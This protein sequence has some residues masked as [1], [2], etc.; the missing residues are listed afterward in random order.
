MS[1]KVRKQPNGKGFGKAGW[2]IILYA[3]VL[4][5]L[6]N[7]AQTDG[8]NLFVEAFSSQNGWDANSVL[9]LSTPAG[10][11]GILAGIP[12]GFLT[13]KKGPKFVL[14]ACLVI[15][16][17]S[18]ACYGFS[19]T[20][21][22]YAVSLI[23]MCCTHNCFAVIAINTLL[24][25]WFPKKK[26]LALGWATMGMNLSSALYTPILSFLL[27]RFTLGS[28]VGM[29]AFVTLL[30]GVITV[31]VI[32]DTPEECGCTPDN[33]YLT[34]AQ[35]AANNAEHASYV[36]KNTF[37]SLLKDKDIWMCGLTYGC[38]ML[39]TTGIMSQL[40]SRLMARG[41]SQTNAI[42]VMSIAAVIGL[43]GSY[44]WGLLDTKLGTKKATVIFGVWFAASIGMNVIQ[45]DIC[46]YLSIFMIGIS[47]GGTAN[48]APSMTTT[49]YGRREFPLAFTVVNTMFCMMKVSSYAVL[50]LVL[51][52]TASYD[53]AYV[54]FMLITLLGAFLASRINDTPKDERGKRT[55]EEGD[56]LP[57]AAAEL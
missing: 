56:R 45:S 19:T 34:E 38:F 37:R 30:M 49:I 28:S 36:P 17:I 22:M 11:V 13:M 33:E 31:L 10:Y 23:V 12:L 46:L 50:A 26:G 55:E 44:L 16:A 21:P 2:L 5:F 42:S 6:S 4:M 52:F 15:G 29:I 8:L 32:K 41:F 35:I 7:G 39:T 40:V 1:T 43:A 54:V 24:A 27:A 48:F 25:N 9:A 47:I 14:A 57:G 3:A 18:M 51:T 20:I 53:V